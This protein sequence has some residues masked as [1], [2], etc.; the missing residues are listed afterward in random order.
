M[1]IHSVKIFSLLYSNW[2]HTASLFCYLLKFSLIQITATLSLNWASF[3][4]TCKCAY[5]WVYALTYFY[6]YIIWTTNLSLITVDKLQRCFIDNTYYSTF[7]TMP[8]VSLSRLWSYFMIISKMFVCTVS[9]TCSW[10]IVSCLLLIAVITVII[11]DH[12]TMLRACV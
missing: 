3:S 5:V 8:H 4:W 10:D 1:T 6:A 11:Q 9:L 12:P 2:G 7:L